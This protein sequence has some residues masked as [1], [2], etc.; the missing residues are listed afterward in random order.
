MRR[1][2][3][4]RSSRRFSQIRN[5]GRVWVNNHLV[6]RTLS[7]GDAETRFG[8][9]ATRRIGNAVVRNRLRRRLREILR[10]APVKTGWDLVFI[11][12]KQS[13]GASFKTLERAAYNLLRRSNLL[14]SSP[15]SD[16][17]RC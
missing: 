10:V 16:S 15:R 12:R 7:N 5:E 13:V 4:L 6:L 1:D 11:V 17:N 14:E 8:F 9:I 2:Q 3:R